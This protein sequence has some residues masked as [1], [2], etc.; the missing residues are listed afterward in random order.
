MTPF[1]ACS[2]AQWML[3]TIIDDFATSLDLPDRARFYA[4]LVELLAERRDR[5]QRVLEMG[6]LSRD[7]FEQVQ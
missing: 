3:E 5:A 7:T 4:L 6:E 1:H 2:E